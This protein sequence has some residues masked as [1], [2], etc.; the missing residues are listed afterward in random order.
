L[1]RLEFL[2]P[3]QLAIALEPRLGE[4]AARDGDNDG[5]AR[6]AGMAAIAEA[7]A[8]ADRLDVGERAGDS[9]AG[10]P[11]LQLAHA[12]GVDQ[13]AA[14]GEQHELTARRRVPPAAVALAHLARAQEF[15]P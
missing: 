9:L 8:L 15:L 4:H 12:R 11:Q 2:L 5:A 14:A 6:L 1:R 10:L 3:L 7:A 13:D